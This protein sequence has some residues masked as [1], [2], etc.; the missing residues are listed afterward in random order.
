M[1]ICT[2][3][4]SNASTT[5]NDDR[6]GRS[7]PRARACRAPGAFRCSLQ[8][9]V[10]TGLFRI[11]EPHVFI[12]GIDQDRKK[13]KKKEKETN[14]AKRPTNTVSLKELV[15]L[16]IL[17]ALGS[18]VSSKKEYRRSPDVWFQSSC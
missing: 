9:R 10:G 2:Q 5:L 13:K 4:R 8:S 16:V 15:L 1:G 7:S 12:V 17:G 6:P 14:R 18:T 3:Y 11:S